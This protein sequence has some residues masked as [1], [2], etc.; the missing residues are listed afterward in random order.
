[1]DLQSITSTT[2]ASK[3]RA[4]SAVE[5]MPLLPPSYSPITPSIT[6]ISCR[7]AV[8]IKVFTMVSLDM[9]Q[10]SMLWAGLPLASL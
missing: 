8:S 5:L 10:V 1:M 6:A 7:D 3:R 9:S 2:G 4:I